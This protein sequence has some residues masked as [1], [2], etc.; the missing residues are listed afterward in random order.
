MQR[1]NNRRHST[2]T[3]NFSGCSCTLC[4]SAVLLKFDALVTSYDWSFPSNGCVSRGFD[5]NAV[6]FIRS[7]AEAKLCLPK[8]N[9]VN[10]VH[11]VKCDCFAGSA[12]FPAQLLLIDPAE[13]S[14]ACAA[15][16][17]LLCVQVTA[18]TYVGLSSAKYG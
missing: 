2:E 16:E 7:N 1:T 11:G 5:E 3:K 9:S 10:L 4:Q 17:P 15:C 6:S 14:A 13:G 12:H 8:T 18:L